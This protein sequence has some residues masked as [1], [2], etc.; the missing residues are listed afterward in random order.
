MDTK[1]H[2][3]HLILPMALWERIKALAARNRRAVTQEIIIAIEDRVDDQEKANP[4][5]TEKG[6]A[7]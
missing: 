1:K 3:F 4:P 6:S 7:P 5:A 2:R